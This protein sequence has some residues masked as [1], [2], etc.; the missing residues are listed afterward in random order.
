MF[1]V[2]CVARG[3]LTGSGLV[4]YAATGEVC[5]IALPAG[6]VDG[7]AAA[8]ADLH[9]GDQGR[10]RRPRRERLLRRR[11]DARSA[12]GRAADAARRSP[13]PSTAGPRRSPA[14]GGSSWPTPS[15]SSAAGRRRGA[16]R[17]GRR[18]AHPGLVAV[19][20]GGRSGSRAG[21]SR[22]T[23][24]R[25]CATGCCRRSPGGTGR[26]AGRRRRC[27]AEV[28][29]ADPRPVRRGLRAAHR[30]GRSEDRVRPGTA[31]RCGSTARPRSSST[32][33]PTPAP[34]RPGSPACVA[35]SC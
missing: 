34:D 21:P 16:D 10:G 20:A 25:S 30:R 19:L 23:T 26:P 11:G 31:S 17:A 9:P 6:L 2:E 8:R 15:S 18:G 3:Y 13:W 27:P 24:S 12:T 4:D 7:V 29:R 1:P 28:D 35:S 5:G 33:S 22:R 32:T 14:S